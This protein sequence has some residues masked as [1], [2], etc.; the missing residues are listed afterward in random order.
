MATGSPNGNYGPTQTVPRNGE[1]NLNPNLSRDPVGRLCGLAQA[2][3]CEKMISTAKLWLISLLILSGACARQH[4]SKPSAG[5]PGGV[6]ATP[7]AV[8]DA[9]REAR[10]KK[11]WRKCFDCLT[12]DAQ[13]SMV[14]ELVFQCGLGGSERAPLIVKEFVDDKLQSDFDKKF[15]EKFGMDHATFREKLRSDPNVAAQ[16]TSEHQL[17]CDVVAAHVRDRAGFFE[18]VSNLFDQGDEPLGE[19]KQI[20]VDGDT[21]SGQTESMMQHLSS[22][23]DGVYKVVR[24]RYD[25][26]FQFRKVNGGWLIDL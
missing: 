11:E 25:K 5:L 7:A 20:M 2:T 13:K 19:L 23:G 3:H 21:A 1:R 12:P 24:S 4:D 16:E 15:K 14:F 17:L 18:A 8:F 22:S 9:Y 6:Y 10:R 26:T